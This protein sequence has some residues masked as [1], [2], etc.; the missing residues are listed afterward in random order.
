M[1]WGQTYRGLPLQFFAFTCGGASGCSGVAHVS[2]HSWTKGLVA[3]RLIASKV[4]ACWSAV[5]VCC[6]V[7]NCLGASPMTCCSGPFHGI[8]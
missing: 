1:L 4:A 8:I 7:S 5:A 3:L 6:V 2:L